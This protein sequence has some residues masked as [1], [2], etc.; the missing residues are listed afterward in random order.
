MMERIQLGSTGIEIEKNGFGCL[1]IQRISREEA[2]HLLRKAV[3]GGIN[4]FDTARAYSDSEEKMGYAFAGMRDKVVIA[5]KTHAQTGAELKEHLETTLKNLNT[6]YIDV[7]QFHNPAFV[8]R[9]GGED[10]LYD[11]A[12][13]AK[14]QGRIRHIGITNHRLPVAREAIESGLYATLQFPYSYLSG[15]QDRELVD[16]C[17]EKGMGF[18]AMKGMAGGLLANGTAA[19]AW[20]AQQEGV[21]PIWGVQ[22][23]W[24]LDQFLAAVREAPVLTPELQAVIEKDRAELTGN[25]CRS[26]GYCMP[27]PVGIQ[28]NQCAR[29]SLMLRRMPEADYLTEYWQGEMKK[30]E[31][32]LHCGQCASKCPYGLNTPQL[33][34][35]NYKEYWTH[36]E[37]K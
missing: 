17:R 34:Q 16:K 10:G 6:D 32:C 4:Y 3:D 19:A 22:H 36:F 23:E 24:E 20:M 1:P 5:T 27:C 12:L 31:N 2:V 29:M 8:P 7:Y 28:I 13:E 21:V 37:N 33:L 11:A 15:P 35:D 26:C 9:P 14:K 25:F 30:I 18:V